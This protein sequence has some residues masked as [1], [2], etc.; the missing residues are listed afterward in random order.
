MGVWVCV[1]WCVGL[2]VCVG[3]WLQECVCVR[4]CFE[5]LTKAIEAHMQS[6]KLPNLAASRGEN[7]AW[8]KWVGW[9]H[10]LPAGDLVPPPPQHP[11]HNFAIYCRCFSFIVVVFSYQQHSTTE[12]ALDEAAISWRFRNRFGVTL[13]IDCNEVYNVYNCWLKLENYHLYKFCLT[14]SNKTE[15]LALIREIWEW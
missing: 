6:E 14:L 8:G 12:S 2:C 4:A 10:R 9:A 7:V 15:Y 13:C 5:S 3:L 11:E 1:W